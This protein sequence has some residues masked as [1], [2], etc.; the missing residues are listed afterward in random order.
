L[1]DTVKECAV[2]NYAQLLSFSPGERGGDWR[3]D[4]A[5]IGEAAQAAEGGIC[6]NDRVLCAAR[7]GEW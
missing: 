3:A 4:S 7:N 2:E 5:A 6:V 1:F